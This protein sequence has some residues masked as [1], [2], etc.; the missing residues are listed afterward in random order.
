M[1]ELQLI[2]IEKAA[3]MIIEAVAVRVAQRDAAIG[4]AEKKHIPDFDH[5]RIGNALCH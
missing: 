3:I 4:L 1:P 5:N 2:P